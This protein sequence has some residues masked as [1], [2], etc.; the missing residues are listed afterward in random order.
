MRHGEAGEAARDFDRA[1]TAAG[2]AQATRSASALKRAGAAP[3]TIWH[4]PYRRTEETAQLA[5]E[6]FGVRLVMDERLVPGGHGETVA[7]WLLSERQG[8]LVVAHMPILPAALAALTGAHA[9]FTTAGV[10]H[11]TVV[12]GHATLVGLYTASFLEHVR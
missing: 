11:I 12:G 3:A 5:A 4:S 8:G 10:A 2:R 1:L 6:V 7:T 9:S